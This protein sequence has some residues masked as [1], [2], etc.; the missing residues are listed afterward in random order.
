MTPD[1]REAQGEV[2][3]AL[4]DLVRAFAEENKQL[5]AELKA[6]RLY[7]LILTLSLVASSLARIWP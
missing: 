5:R 6:S 4:R 2:F 7:M 3:E 1:E